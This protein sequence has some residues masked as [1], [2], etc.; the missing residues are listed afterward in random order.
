MAINTKHRSDEAEIMDDFSVQGEELHDALNKIAAINKLL[1]GNN[2]T[3]NGIK[4]LL[5][6]ISSEQVIT[7][8]DIGCGNG[9]MLRML[10]DYAIGKGLKFNLMGIDANDNT[11]IHARQLSEKYANISY[12]CVDIFST[13]FATIKYDIVL[14][15]LTLHHFKDAEIE[16]VL[17]IF[18]SNATIGVVIND[19]HRSRVAYF[20]FGIICNIF[21]LKRLPREDGLTSILKGFKKRDL[22]A[23]EHK[24]QVEKFT[25]KWKWAFRYQW[26]IYNI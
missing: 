9:D 7:I 3:L 21:S 4:K 12:R 26:I 5:E 13:E 25:I 16:S 6:N 18:K 8:A 22:E 15:T 11:V 14:C 19:L 23:F 1:G 17:R 2:V 10:S 20:L 24:L